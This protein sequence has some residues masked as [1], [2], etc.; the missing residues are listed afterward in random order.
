MTV[1]ICFYN[2][3]LTFLP[4]NAASDQ[5]SNAWI[6]VQSFSTFFISWHPFLNENMGKLEG[7]HLLINDQVYSEYQHAVR[8]YN[9]WQHP[10]VTRHPNCK[11]LC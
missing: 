10:S 9:I 8:K 5:V 6:H 7:T 1:G 11:P 3:W 4:I 2:L